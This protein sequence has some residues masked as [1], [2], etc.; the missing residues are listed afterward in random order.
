MK[1]SLAVL[2][3]LLGLGVFSA[4]AVGQEKSPSDIRADKVMPP[5]PEVKAKKAVELNSADLGTD[6]TAPAT[7]LTTQTP[8]ESAPVQNVDS[9]LAPEVD[10]AVTQMSSDGMLVPMSVPM[11]ATAGCVCGCPVVSACPVVKCQPAADVCESLRPR[12]FARGLRL[13]CRRSWR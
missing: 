13:R 12:R 8:T 9:M 11:A 6:Q 10:P 2:L 7:N 5:M 1:S 3:V 4:D